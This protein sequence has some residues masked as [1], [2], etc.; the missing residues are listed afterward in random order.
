MSTPQTEKKDPSVVPEDDFRLRVEDI[1]YLGETGDMFA[2]FAKPKGETKLPGVIVISEVW[3]LVPH[4]KDVARRVR[5][6]PCA[7]SR[8]LIAFGGN[9][10]RP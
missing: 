6:I 9:A 10:R 4:I 7:R 3:G 8:R 1:K 2:H 5:G